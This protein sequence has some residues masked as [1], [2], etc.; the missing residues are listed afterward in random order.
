MEKKDAQIVNPSPAD[1]ST[2]FSGEF[3]YFYA[4]YVSTDGKSFIHVYGSENTDKFSIPDF[5]GVIPMPKLNLSDFK[6][7]TFH[8]NDLDDFEESSDYFKYY[9]TIPLATSARQ[10]VVTVLN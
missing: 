10:R 4:Y 8:L 6:L 2:T 1:F 3:D 9:S 7:R 5:S